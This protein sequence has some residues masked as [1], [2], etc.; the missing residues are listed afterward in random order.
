MKRSSDKAFE[1]DKVTLTSLVEKWVGTDLARAPIAGYG[2]SIKWEIWTDRITEFLEK[3]VDEFDYAGVLAFFIQ[4]SI[5]HH[6]GSYEAQ[7]FLQKTTMMKFN[8]LGYKKEL[9]AI[10]A[11]IKLLLPLYVPDSF[12]EKFNIHLKYGIP[13]LLKDEQ[14]RWVRHYHDLKERPIWEQRKVDDE[15]CY[16]I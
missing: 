3:P 8:G 15:T 9:V 14:G 6:Y 13:W 1:P 7:I 4:N 16:M 2:C 5:L 11:R 12:R 10:V